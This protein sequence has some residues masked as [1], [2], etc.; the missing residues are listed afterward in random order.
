M[1]HAAFLVVGALVCAPV[2]AQTLDATEEPGWVLP[3]G[4]IR[5]LVASRALLYGAPADILHYEAPLGV[6]DMIAHIERHHPLLRNLAVLP[7]MAVLAGSHG[8]CSS[9]A[10]ISGSE[11][12]RS[13]GTLSRVCWDR[14]QPAA[15]APD[16][17]PEGGR[18]VFDFAEP[19]FPD[20]QMQQIWRYEQ[21]AESVKRQLRERLNRH[22]WKPA[23]GSPGASGWRSWVRGSQGLS[24][25]LF[26]VEGGCVL[27][28]LRFAD[29]QESASG[30]ERK[31]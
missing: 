23:S 29:G 17:L 4:S 24:V 3:E 10:T 11:A 8:T 26:A 12:G 1:K 27:A 2:R 15:A 16:W 5:T 30:M 7:G 6:V 31:P 19:A 25:D 13:T 22:G 20:G 18:R 9:M 21:P 28:L 14:A